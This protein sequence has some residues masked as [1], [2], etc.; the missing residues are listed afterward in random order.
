MIIVTGGAGFIGSN[1]VHALNTAGE[2][3]IVVVDDL[4]EGD[5]CR[6]LSR[7]R[8]SD[9][10][11][12]EAL[13]ERLD[14]LPKPRAV[15]HQ[16]ACSST[17]ERNGRFLLANNID[18]SKRLISWCLE[19]EVPVLFAGSA[20]VYGD[21]E[22]GFSDDDASCEEPLNAYAF[23]KWVVDG[24]IRKQLPALRSQLVSLRYFNVYG[25]NELHKEGMCSP[26][27]HFHR[28]INES[29]AIKLFA[30]SEAFRRDFIHV[31]DCCAVNLWFLEHGDCSG[32]YNCGTGSARSFTDVG[33]IMSPLYD[34]GSVNEVPFP[35]HLKG[36]YQAYTQADLS[37]LRAVGCDHEFTSLEDGVARYVAVLQRDGGYRR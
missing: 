15:L 2:D 11:D 19:R 23:S 4:T 1:L 3:D 28:Q 7:A 24:W 5:K 37:R 36:K 21:G 17:T 10:I 25:P 9:L 20:S 30:G 13:F 16:G 14:Q 35:D 34:G 18:Y 6:N 33:T 12:S 27:C 29:G 26:V 31:D 8:F 22:R 32:V